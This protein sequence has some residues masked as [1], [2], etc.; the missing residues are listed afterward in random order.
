MKRYL[1]ILGYIPFGY[2]L[3]FG[4]GIGNWGM[5]YELSIYSSTIVE[6]LHA[7]SLHK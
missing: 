6:T 5:R 2:R 4:D 7:T 1:G 3:S